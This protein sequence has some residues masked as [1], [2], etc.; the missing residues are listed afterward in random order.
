MRSAPWADRAA[1][2]PCGAPACARRP[3]VRW[4]RVSTACSTASSPATLTRCAPV[5]CGARA[6][7]FSPTRCAR[8]A[9]G[10]VSRRLV[11]CRYDSWALRVISH[12]CAP[13]DHLAR[14]L[15]F[16]SRPR[17]QGVRRGGHD[18]LLD[19]FSTGSASS[20]RRQAATTRSAHG[21]RRRPASRAAS[22]RAPT[23]HSA[24]QRPASPAQP[25]CRHIQTHLIHSNDP[26][27]I[28]PHPIWL[29]YPIWQAPP[30]LSG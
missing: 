17:A 27:Q 10:V 5:R 20:A 19:G 30:T 23:P 21:V 15:P 24:A 8:A 2:A 13:C 7:L 11:L 22:A 14:A 29:A 12:R 4:R 9:A 6:L 28:A 16:S 25:T 26:I 3:R 1:H 18:A